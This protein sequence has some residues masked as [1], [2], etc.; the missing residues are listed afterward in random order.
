MYPSSLYINTSLLA[1]GIFIRYYTFWK[2]Q[3]FFQKNHFCHA[4]CTCDSAYYA[5]GF[6]PSEQTTAS[7]YS[8]S[9]VAS[10]YDT[11]YE[12]TINTPKK[13]FAKIIRISYYARK[14]PTLCTGT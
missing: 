4:S 9:H 5:S 14:I 11:F 6:I 13:K 12:T 2:F 10:R 3:L 7:F 8:T 1:K